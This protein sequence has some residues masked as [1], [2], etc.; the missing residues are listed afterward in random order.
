MLYGAS[1]VIE[2]EIIFILELLD[3]KPACHEILV[4]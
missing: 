2:A 3:L 1:V 4:H